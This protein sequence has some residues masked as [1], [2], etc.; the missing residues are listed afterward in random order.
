MR[1]VGPETAAER[2]VR[3]W[4]EHQRRTNL[5]RLEAGAQTLIQLITGVYGVLFA[6]LALSDQ[7][8]YLSRSVVV[9]MGSIGLVVFFAAL[10]AAVMVVIPRPLRYQLD[11]LTEMQHTYERLVRR[12]ATML[13][14]AQLG[15]LLGIA[16]LIAVILAVLWQW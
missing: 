14:V 12:K 5:E 4:F 10:I 1:L 11:N 13:V 15:F 8:V 9:W 7:P 2:E 16:C 6:V 3:E